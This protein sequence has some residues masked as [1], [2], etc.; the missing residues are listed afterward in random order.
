MDKRT[1]IRIAAIALGYVPRARNSL[2]T[3]QERLLEQILHVGDGDFRISAFS[4]HLRVISD[5]G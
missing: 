5:I 4:I 2:S 3:V 1:R